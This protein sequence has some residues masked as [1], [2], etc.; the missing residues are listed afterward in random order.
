MISPPLPPESWTELRPGQ[1]CT[2]SPCAA[3]FNGNGAVAVSGGG[4]CFVAL[5]DH[6]WSF[7]GRGWC[8]GS[9]TLFFTRRKK[10]G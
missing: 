3:G 5:G 10:N 2:Y 4:V 1:T 9:L 8:G 6:G 7:K